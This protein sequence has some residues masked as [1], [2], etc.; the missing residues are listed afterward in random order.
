[1]YA[2]WCWGQGGWSSLAGQRPSIK[3]KKKHLIFLWYFSDTSASL[4]ITKLTLLSPP[5]SLFPSTSGV[6]VLTSSDVMT[7]RGYGVS[8]L[9]VD[10]S[11]LCILFVHLIF[12]CSVQTFRPSVWEIIKQNNGTCR[13]AIVPNRVSMWPFLKQNPL[14]WSL[15]P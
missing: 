7:T 8:W 13:E 9:D 3:Q 6:W 10:I 12:M 5:G 11:C 2:N 1:M 14:L 15:L 4:V